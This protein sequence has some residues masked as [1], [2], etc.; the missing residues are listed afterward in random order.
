[1]D[2]K[3]DSTEVRALLLD[4]VREVSELVKAAAHA[5][6]L[7]VMVL[8]ADGPK[9]LAYI[10][11]AT[12][13]SKT[14]LS[15]HVSRMLG[16]GLVERLE[17]G[18]YGLTED[19]GELLGAIAGFYSGSKA[20]EEHRAERVM[21]EH[22]RAFAGAGKGDSE[23]VV[24]REPVYQGCWI[25]Y[26]G[27]VSGVLKSLGKDRDLV[28]VGG[29]TGYAFVS[30]VAKG[31]TCPSGPTALQCWPAILRATGVLGYK[32]RSFEDNRSF[33]QG[34]PLGAEDVER[35]RRTFAVVKREVDRDRP[36]VL[37]GL[38]IPEYG[39]VKGYRGDAYLVSTYRRLLGKPDDPIRYDAL[40]APGCL[41]VVSFWEEAPAITA[42]DDR[43]ALR[44]AIKMAEGD[45]VAPR[46]YVAGPAA[47]DE[48]A[49]VLEA[50]APETLLYQG[51]A[52]VAQ[53]L[54]EAKGLAAAFLRR[55]AKRYAG[56]LH[57]DPLMEAAREYAASEGLLKQFAGIF[58]FA[59]E[60]T[61]PLES[62]T[63]GARLL[64]AVRPREE[65]AVARMKDVYKG[66]K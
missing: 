49:G 21:E 47:F 5:S 41:H 3:P 39:I 31:K 66:W 28:D 9:E 8:L 25:S 23:R 48:W 63:N 13:L 55:L 20:R 46:G 4:P 17:R 43:E 24:S 6:R 10:Q 54:H 36:V 57:A 27:A 65:A 50:G 14:A 60:G 29:Y 52:Y 26:L 56:R 7:Q 53:C 44:R 62:R 37:W 51:N 1:M 32:V 12:G 61:M 45:S 42:R 40:E 16:M 33:P 2:K 35:A 18:S 30:N 22:S 59:L 11:G 19:G 58:P 38:D 15:N 64:R 34:R